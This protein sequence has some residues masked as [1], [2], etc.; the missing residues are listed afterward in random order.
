MNKQ[1][2]E[3]EKLIEICKK[4]W[5]EYNYDWDADMFLDLYQQELSIKDIVFTQEFMDK[6]Y[7]K[8]KPN[9]VYRQSVF[10]SY[11]LNNPVDYLYNLI[12]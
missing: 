1:L 4:I 8:I 11:H 10:I 3:N 5:Y 6:F 9:N 12:K 7:N 2:T